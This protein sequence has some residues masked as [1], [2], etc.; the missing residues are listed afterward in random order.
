VCR[1]PVHGALYKKLLYRSPCPVSLSGSASGSN[2]MRVKLALSRISL[3]LALDHDGLAG[4]H[5]Y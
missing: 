2:C 3:L 4:Q 1:D 5:E